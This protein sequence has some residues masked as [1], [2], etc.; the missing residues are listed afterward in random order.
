MV[1]LVFSGLTRLSQDG[2]VIPDLAESWDVSS[3]GRTV[4]FHLRQGVT[5]H[6]GTPFSSADAVFTYNL[7]GDPALQGDPDQAPLWR[8][9]HRSDPD[10]TT[11]VC[12]LPAPFA[13]FLAYAS[14]GILPRTMLEG[15]TAGNILDNVFNQAPVG[16][17]PYRVAQLAESR[18]VLKAHP[19]YHLGVPAIEE[20]E[21]QFFFDAAGA[22]AAVVRGDAD[23]ILV[24]SATGEAERDAL[25][26]TSGLRTFSA[27][28]TAYTALYMNGSK[29]PL[30]DDDVRNAIAQAIDIESI[31][32]DILGTLAAR[33]TTPM[34]PGTWAFNPDVAPYDHDDEDARD[35]LEQAG[36]V[37]TEGS[38]V[39]VKNDIPLEITLLADR[40]PVRD[41]LAE[42]VAEDLRDVGIGVTVEL[43]DSST[44]ITDSLIPRDYQAAIFGW[45]QG[46]DPDP[47]PAWHSS[48]AGG[49]GRNLAEY[50]SEDADALMEDGRRTFD[51]DQRQ[52]LYYSFQEVFNLDVPSVILYYPVYNYFVRETV[53]GVDLGTLFYTGSRFR[54]VHEWTLDSAAQVVVD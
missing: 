48:Q 42:R 38:D 33:A 19:A 26:G 37:L 47:Y 15:A 2:T 13:P 34:V 50:Q 41:A 16:T 10:P 25:A 49:N 9:V 14:I 4:T 20:I 32:G 52:S 44:L 35:R 18:A 46:L 29:A 23:A 22:A 11:V 53:E 27:N 5:F 3:D 54:N 43:E 7:L 40:D 31:T 39:R 28:R 51:L 1:S 36:W 12:E 21:L 24:D 8:Q 30:N 6:T 17:G 45:D